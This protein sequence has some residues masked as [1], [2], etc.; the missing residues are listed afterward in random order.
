MMAQ[1]QSIP[2]SLQW[3][4]TPTGELYI[5]VVMNIRTDPTGPVLG[6]PL[7]QFILTKE[8]EDGL[9]TVVT[10]LHIAQS[11]PGGRKLLN[12]HGG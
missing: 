12:G 3:G 5:N 7:H 11:I 1:V 8:E 10:G 9:T 4:R 2:P 6:V